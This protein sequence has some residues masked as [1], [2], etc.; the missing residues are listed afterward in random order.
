MLDARNQSRA[1]TDLLHRIAARGD[2]GIGNAYIEAEPLRFA[3]GVAKRHL[4]T[5]GIRRIARYINLRKIRLSIKQAKAPT[6]AVLGEVWVAVVNACQALIARRVQVKANL[7]PRS[8]KVVL[9][10]IQ[11]ENQTCPLRVA[12]TTANR[13]KALLF[14]SEINIDQIVVARQFNRLYFSGAKES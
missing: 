9:L 10:E 13:A 5:H 3:N 11:P 8:H 7:A 4:G 6:H 2:L 12:Q 1:S 14:N